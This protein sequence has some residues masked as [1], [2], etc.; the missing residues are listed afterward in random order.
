[1]N[2]IEFI[3]SYLDFESLYY[4]EG[5]ELRNNKVDVAT[6]F[7]IWY[8]GETQKWINIRKFEIT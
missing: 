2:Q 4:Q 7:K 8:G 6:L 3:K 1:M 5:I